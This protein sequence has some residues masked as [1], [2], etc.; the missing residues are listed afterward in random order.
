MVASA[1]QMMVFIF[2]VL[3]PE[4]Y[5]Q[6]PALVWFCG[7][8]LLQNRSKHPHFQCLTGFVK[9]LLKSSRYICSSLKVS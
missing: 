9:G 5:A 6:T 1:V 4:I 2:I 3:L 8:L 7:S